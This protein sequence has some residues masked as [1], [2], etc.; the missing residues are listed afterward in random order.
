MRLKVLQKVLNEVTLLNLP[1][2][3]G[4]FIPTAATLH[5]ELLDH[6]AKTRRPGNPIV[7]TS[8]DIKPAGSQWKLAAAMLY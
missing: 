7:L 3:P 5:P 8:R 6:T 1:A 4:H 2:M